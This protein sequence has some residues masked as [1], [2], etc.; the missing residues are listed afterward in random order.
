VVPIFIIM[1]G[2][3]VSLEAAY[4][5]VETT[6]L[7]L[8]AGSEPLQALLLQE[9]ELGYRQLQAILEPA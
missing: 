9:A 4:R 3:E 8:A 1:L 2:K 7:T 6:L 5:D